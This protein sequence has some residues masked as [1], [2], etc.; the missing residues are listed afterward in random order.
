MTDRH[1]Y[2]PGAAGARDHDTQ[3]GAES[4]PLAELARLI[5]QT[6]PNAKLGRANH[7]AVA[8]Q[9]QQHYEDQYADQL[10]EHPTEAEPAPPSWMR[11]ASG[12]NWQQ[13]APTMHPQYQADHGHDHY[14]AEQQPQ[15]HRQHE[16]D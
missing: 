8:P 4:D 15:P 10:A 6:D 2:H 14:P 12:S 11:A 13:P 1:Q 9:A 7:V 5:G 16:T 3:R